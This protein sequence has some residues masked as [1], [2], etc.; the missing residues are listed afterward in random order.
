MTGKPDGLKTLAQNIHLCWAKERGPKI[1]HHGAVIDLQELGFD[2]SLNY[3]LILATLISKKKRSLIPRIEALLNSQRLPHL[4]V[5]DHDQ[6][7]LM[8]RIETVLPDQITL[9]YHQYVRTSKQSRVYITCYT[10]T[11]EILQ[12]N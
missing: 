9:Y 8:S 6:N 11:K 2:G 3:D 4:L 12:C 1:R 5:P 10:Y 7:L